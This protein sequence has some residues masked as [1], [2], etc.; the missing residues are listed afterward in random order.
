[1]LELIVV[2]LGIET[3]PYE[4]LFGILSHNYPLLYYQYRILCVE[5]IRL[6]LTKHSLREYNTIYSPLMDLLYVYRYC[7]KQAAKIQ[8]K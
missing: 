7:E 3:M 6:I 1:M 4:A 8:H 5:A 2:K